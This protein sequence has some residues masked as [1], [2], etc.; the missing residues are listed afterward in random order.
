MTDGGTVV[1]PYHER[2]IPELLALFAR[3]FGKTMSAEAWRWKLLG[4]PSGACNVWLAQSDGRLVFQY[5]GIAR[6]CQ[7][8]GTLVPAY[9]S[10]DAMTDP[11]YRRRG[12]LTRVV[13]EAH[14]EW[15]NAGAAFTIGL[16][17]QQW[18]SRTH[19]LGW[20][21]LFPLRWLMRPLRPEA[22]LARRARLPILRRVPGVAAAFNRFFDRR[23]RRNSSAVLREVS[24]ADKTFDTFWLRLRDQYD[25]AMVRDSAWVNW[26]FL[27]SAP[28]AIDRYRGDRWFAP[29]NSSGMPRSASSR[30]RSMSRRSSPSS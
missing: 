22:F 3:V 17:N 4:N 6:H 19:A 14:N 8:A 28:S 26:R 11:D 30:T 16:P 7:L 10:V 12:L 24:R 18:G 1:R 15:R 23:L 20:R 27:Q 9:V 13:T 25:F 29:E 2:D 21:E 5:A